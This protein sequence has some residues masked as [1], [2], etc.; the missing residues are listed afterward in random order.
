[1]VLTISAMAQPMAQPDCTVPTALPRC[2]ARIT[3]PIST[4]PAAHSPPKPKPIRARAIKSCSKLWAK[5]LRKVKTENHRM[6]S[7][8][9]RTRPMRSAS[10]PAAQPPTAEHSSV[11]VAIWPAWALVR[12]HSAMMV[13]ITKL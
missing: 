2:S 7:C 9:V 1:M 11:T 6:V 12:L 5:P 10:S 4:A 3:S 8:S 13:G